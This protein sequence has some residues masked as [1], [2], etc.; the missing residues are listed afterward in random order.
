[1]HKHGVGRFAATE[2]Q[3]G[4]PKQRVKISDVFADKVVLLHGRVVDVGLVIYADFVQ[5]VFQ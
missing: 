2:V 1:M 4:G 3:H 5:V